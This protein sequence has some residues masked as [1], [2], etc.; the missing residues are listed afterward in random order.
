M[1]VTSYQMD[2]LNNFAAKLNLYNLNIYTYI[3]R[4]SGRKGNLR[5]SFVGQLKIIGP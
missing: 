1:K 2:R 4:V 5:M 3:D